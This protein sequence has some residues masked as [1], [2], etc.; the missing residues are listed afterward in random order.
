MKQLLFILVAAGFTACVNSTGDSTI[1][2]HN[3]EDSTTL[4][5]E[6][7]SIKT[8]NQLLDSLN[9]VQL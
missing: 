8:V 6:I 5:F 1:I 4:P 7:D 9:Q 2:I 3:P